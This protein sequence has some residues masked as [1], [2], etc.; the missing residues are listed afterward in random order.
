MGTVCTVDLLGGFRVTVDGTTIPENAW[1]PRRGADLVKL[2]T[3][4]PRHRL[5]RE[6]LMDT[7][8]PDL[9][10]DASSRNLRKAVYLARKATGL[11]DAIATGGGMLALFP[12]REVQSDAERFESGAH[13]ALASGDAEPCARA[14]ELYGG[15]LLPEDRYESWAEGPRDRLRLLF[16]ELL[17]A[18]QMWDRVLE[19]E[20]ADEEAHRFLI[21]L[22][23]DRGDRPGAIRRFEQLREH[24]RADLG[25]GPESSSVALYEQA[26]AMDGTAPATMT[27]R[28]RAQLA[29]G[30]VHWN[31][32]EL[33][34]AEG[35]ARDARA[36]AIEAGA[37]RELG[38]ASAI[39]GLVA[40]A[41][42]RWRDLFRSEFTESIRQTP[43]LAPFVFDA[44]LCFA[45][46]SLYGADGCEDVAPFAGELLEEARAAGSADGE[47]LASLMLGEVQLLSGRFDAAEEHLARAAALQ[48]MPDAGSARVVTMQRLAEL[49]LGRGQRWRAGRLLHPA[50]RL[51]ESSFLAPHLTVRIYDGLV[52][53][54]PDVPRSLEAVRRAD[55]AL[56]GRDTCSPCSMGFRVA[57]TIAL[58]RAGELAHARDRLDSA[59]R[60]AGMWQGGPW[61]AA[62][63][64]ARGVLRHAEGD[65]ARAAALFQE[66]AEE[67]ARLRRPNDEA[68]CREAAGV[69]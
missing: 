30:L 65:D 10:P 38:E 46:F 14:A 43:D 56:A 50:L 54:A 42:G 1:R 6:Q 19:I 17:R 5:H 64:E 29:W 15:E 23:L 21:Q 39:L 57:A 67:F 22:A 9:S 31:Q 8:W 35:A 61:V 13:D 44:H 66:A 36:L 33:E 25:V 40:S 28:I 62:V 68:R 55:A 4:A 12:G 26:L 52:E 24:L 11:P 51:A 53:A 20:P 59:E 47:A 16:L 3:L 2:L 37:G 45:E 60:I 69:A 49:A 7:L 27:D 63:W 18:A 48:Q 34:E 32:G 58:A 41:R